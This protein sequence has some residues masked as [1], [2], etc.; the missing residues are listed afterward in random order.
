MA[1]NDKA[2][3]TEDSDILESVRSFIETNE[4]YYKKDRSDFRRSK[5][6]AAGNG[7]FERLSTA[8]GE[9]R[10]NLTINPL[11]KIVDST[12]NSFLRNPFR[13]DGLGDDLNEQINKALFHCLRDACN[14]GLGYLYI[15]HTDDGAIKFKCLSNIHVMRSRDRALVIDKKRVKG[16]SSRLNK[17]VWNNT[18][19]L[20]LA[21]DEI[22]VVTYFELKD[23]TVSIYRIENDE[24]TARTSLELPVLP[25]IRVK[26]KLVKLKNEDHYRGYYYEF[27]DT[28][29]AMNAYMSRAAEMAIAKT[30][31]IMA[32][33]S[34]PLNAQYQ[35]AWQS[36]EP[37]NLY[38]Y[39]G[40]RE[41]EGFSPVALPKPDYS[42]YTQDLATLNNQI[43]LLSSFI[44]GLSG[45]NLQSEAAGSETATA[46]LDRRESRQDAQ[47]ELLFYLNNSA[48]KAARLL[49]AYIS[50]V[51]GGKPGIKVINRM[52]MA[53]RNK[54]ALDLY[55]SLLSSNTPKPVAIEWLK[56]FSCPEEIIGILSR[57]DAEDPVKDELARKLEEVTAAL[58][59]ERSRS[60]LV[61]LQTQSNMEIEKRKM[62]IDYELSTA[63][64]AL[65]SRRLAIEEAK[66]GID[67]QIK[68]QE[69]EIKDA[70]AAAQI[71][72][73]M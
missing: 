70:T 41:V 72:E 6:L 56:L 7:W 43:T 60:Q 21:A 65:D 40:F 71:A 50:A 44:D 34:M 17:S 31:V 59:A 10:S 3:H 68:Q 67:A 26:G 49:E 20:S 16:K 35:E 27:Q 48:H 52:D 63:R 46:V 8:W 37:R 66:L 24:I 73:A 53:F 32:E 69:I 15:Y 39:K 2:T 5:N 45:M 29:A 33:E 55:M 51:G 61:L 58:E 42:P 13:F 18:D 22:P 64:L 4:S 1:R 9:A 36:N 62:E 11:K 14:D 57:P 47:S 25:I 54:N 28:V 19:V 38:L 12:C 30:P 23:G